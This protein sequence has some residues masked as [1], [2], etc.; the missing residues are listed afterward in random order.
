MA[1]LSSGKEGRSVVVEGAGA[2]G[3]AA[4]GVDDE[5]EGGCPGTGAL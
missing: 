1:C 3:G 4:A 2:A 5:A